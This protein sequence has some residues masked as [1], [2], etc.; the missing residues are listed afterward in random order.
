MSLAQSDRELIRRMQQGERSAYA[1][2]IDSY[3]ARVLRLARRYVAAPS[4]AEDLVQEIFVEIYRSVGAFRGES[5]LS[6]YVYS[7]AVHRCQRHA[8]SK[9]I[10]PLAIL[11]SEDE[12][13][14][15]WRNSP[16]ASAVKGELSDRVHIA[17]GELTGI[18]R[19]VVILHELHGLTYQE[20][21]SVLE[22]PVGTVKSRLSGAFGRLRKSLHGYV[23]GEN[24]PVGCS[25]QAKRGREAAR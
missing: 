4:D 7:I 17:M 19:D 13:D 10:Q 24:A 25:P 14:P 12:R 16:E 2:F 22:I 23:F 21:A 20:C 6:T 9:R 5:S 3:G 15:D 1:E 18:Q 8:Q 11:E